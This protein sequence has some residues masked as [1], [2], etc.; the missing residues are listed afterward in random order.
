MQRE[1]ERIR[2]KYGELNMM[3]RDL[4]EHY[5]KLKWDNSINDSSGPKPAEYEIDM[6][7]ARI[8]EQER[9]IVALR[10]AIGQQNGLD[11]DYVASIEFEGN[12]SRGTQNLGLQ[13]NNLQKEVVASERMIKEK[14]EEIDRLKDQLK[15]NFSDERVQNK[16]EEYENRL[17]E[18]SREHRK[19]IEKL[20][21]EYSE[22]VAEMENNFE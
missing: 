19:M 13:I 18:A 17:K 21:N 2:M 14:D 1:N 10:K 5:T 8:S 6:L 22:T 16:I 9:L 3:Y 11:E 12:S 15:E 4:E 20:S 7:N